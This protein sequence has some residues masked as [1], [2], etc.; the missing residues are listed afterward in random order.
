[1]AI[2]RRFTL[3][4]DFV[5]HCRRAADDLHVGHSGQAGQDFI[6]HAVCEVSVLFLAAQIR[7]GK[8]G[9][10]LLGIGA[11]PLPP[12]APE[13]AAAAGGRDLGWKKINELTPARIVDAKQSSY[14]SELRA[15]AEALIG[16]TAPAAASIFTSLS[17]LR[18]LRIA[19]SASL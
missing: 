1:L 6:L 15:N 17:F 2:S 11:A 3:C 12:I 18:D 5:Q 8:N 19:E 10:A 7:E 16:R 13:A 4:T 14:Q 9:D